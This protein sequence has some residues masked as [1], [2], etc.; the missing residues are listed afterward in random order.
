[1]L[2]LKHWWLL[3]L[4]LLSLAIQIFDPGLARSQDTTNILFHDDYN[5]AIREAKLTGKPIFLEF[6]C[7][8]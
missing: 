5:R 7:A 8:P 6:R 4:G 2:T 3:G 1:M